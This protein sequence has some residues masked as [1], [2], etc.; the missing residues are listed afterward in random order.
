MPSASMLTNT[1]GGPRRGSGTGAGLR[2]VVAAGATRHR[3]A[4]HQQAGGLD[5]VAAGEFNYGIHDI[6]A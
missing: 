5:K 4:Q 2:R 1:S 6:S 3:H